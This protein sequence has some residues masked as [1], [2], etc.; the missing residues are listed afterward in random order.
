MKPL[1]NTS[2]QE[3]PEPHLVT[4]SSKEEI[5]AA[6]KEAGIN[7]FHYIDDPWFNLLPDGIIEVFVKQQNVYFSD[8]P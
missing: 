3:L 4:Y 5:T 6:L 8:S 1:S 2:S 7:K